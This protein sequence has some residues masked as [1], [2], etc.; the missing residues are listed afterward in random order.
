M[1]LDNKRITHPG[2][3]QTVENRLG[4][5]CAAAG[6]YKTLYPPIITTIRRNDV[7]ALLVHTI[8]HSEIQNQFTIALAS[9]KCQWSLGL[10]GIAF[11]LIL[12]A[13]RGYNW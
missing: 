5:N 3:Y 8:L 9:R 6:K 13:K 1:Y 7:P 4:N 11:F 10:L 12:I 2:I